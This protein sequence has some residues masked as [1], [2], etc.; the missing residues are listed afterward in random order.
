MLVEAKLDPTKQDEFSELFRAIKTS[1]QRS[2]I[3]E[4][5]SKAI[6]ALRS[7]VL[8]PAAEEHVAKIEELYR[9]LTG[10]TS[11]NPGENSSKLGDGEN[12]EPDLSHLNAIQDRLFRERQRMERATG[13]ERELRTVWVAQAEKELA[14][15]YK[16][17]G[18]EP[19]TRE[20]S[21]EEL[22][23]ELRDDSE[24]ATGNVKKTPKSFD[25]TEEVL[26]DLPSGETLPN[27]GNGGNLASLSD[28]SENRINQDSVAGSKPAPSERKAGLR[29]VRG[30]KISKIFDGNTRLWE[31][32]H[33]EADEQMAG[34]QEAA[35]SPMRVAGLAVK[36]ALSKFPRLSGKLRE[37]LTI[38]KEFHRI[39]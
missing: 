4:I 3:A 20:I 21:D 11:P 36:D 32:P 39:T 1:G 8:T 29:I 26:M 5:I 14:D 13:K 15:E 18:I 17:L 35:F 19:E 31:G 30:K 37:E 10:K 33:A 6:E 23:A 16:R 28:Y 38:T 25:V 9:E 34:F 22:L 12:A 7:M 2:A 27:A 24:E